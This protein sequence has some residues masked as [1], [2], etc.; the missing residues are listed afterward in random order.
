MKD[1]AGLC[2][3]MGFLQG[4]LGYLV[5][6]PLDD[7]T[8]AKWIKIPIANFLLYLLL[9]TSKS[10]VLDIGPISWTSHILYSFLATIFLLTTPF[11]HFLFTIESRLLLVYGVNFLLVYGANLLLV[12]VKNYYAHQSGNEG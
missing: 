3:A 2:V 7:M 4:L 9:I 5:F 6:R 10:H 11:P 1:T 12:H 8:Q